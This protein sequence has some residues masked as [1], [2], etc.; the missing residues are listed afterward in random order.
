MS[1]T[2]LITSSS[3]LVYHITSNQ[4]NLNLQTLFGTSKYQ[5]KIDKRII[6]ASGVTLGATTT[7]NYALNMPSGFGGRLILVNEGSILGAGGAANSGTGGNCIN[8]GASNIYIDNRGTIS[9]GGGG[10]G[11]GGTGGQ[12]SFTT[13]YDCSY[14][15]SICTCP[16]C[17]GYPCTNSAPC[18]GGYVSGSGCA[19]GGNRWVCPRT[20][21]TTNYTS[22]GA[23]GNGGRGQGYDAGAASGSGGAT[24][25]TNA[26][27][28]GTGGTGGSYG[29]SGNNGNT[30]ANGNYTNGSA[31]SSGGLAGF[32][33][34]N[35][36]NVN[37]VANGTRNGRIG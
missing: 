2:S 9:S 36:G 10:G 28:G 19:E 22:G 15:A 33:I 24:G 14:A 34:V 29:S 26:G 37:W 18:S 5:A 12:G 21:S 27:T 31:G 13:T 3:S 23:G 7:G 4:E 32:Y 17:C 11:R 20:C 35:N 25:G 6:I 16:V 30:G 8:A 1:L